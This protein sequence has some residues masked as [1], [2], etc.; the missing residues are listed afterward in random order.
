ML[1]RRDL[2]WGGIARLGLVQ[3]ALG[4]VVALTTSTLNRLMVVEVALPAVVP[5]ALV[6]LHHAMQLLRPRMGHGSDRGRRNTPWIVGGMATLSLGGVLAAV[7]TAWMATALV[8]GLVLATVAFALIGLG[9][10]AA[11]TS[12]L[13]LLAKRVAAERRAAAATVVWMLMIAGLGLSATLSGRMLEPYSGARLVAVAAGVSGLAFLLTLLGLRGV[14]G[15][16]GRA[17]PAGGE[18]HGGGPGFRQALAR[19]WVDRDARRFTVFVFVS[20]LAYSAQ[21]LILEPFAGSRFGFSP[22]ASTRLSGTQH[23]G[24]FTGMLLVATVTQLARG[25]GAASL[26]RWV[27]GGCLASAAAMSGLV[28]AALTAMPW[29]LRANVFVLGISNGA[30]SMAAIAAMMALAGKG[31]DARE[32]VRMG[33]WGASQ[34]IAFAAGGALGTVLADLSRW[35]LGSSS[36]AY[37]VV[38]AI[39]V[40]GFLVA[41]VLAREIPFP[42]APPGRGAAGPLPARDAGVA[43]GAA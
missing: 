32:G 23:G 9:V 16:G 7:A 28:L 24:V 11:G 29:P 14:E 19:V 12:L 15:A 30:F 35:A 38:F 39:E 13:V 8:P 21:D 42:D 41:A 26:K 27:V 34:A 20:M 1:P 40:L 31:D 3:A 37:A 18:E 25:T 4:A 10:S 33:L 5:G 17:A 43:Q 36:A 22:G 6:T 2:G